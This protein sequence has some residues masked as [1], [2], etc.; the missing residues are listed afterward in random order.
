M[1][2]VS[3]DYSQIELRIVAHVAESRSSSRPSPTGS[4]STP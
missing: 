2:L 3:A 1:K 4:T